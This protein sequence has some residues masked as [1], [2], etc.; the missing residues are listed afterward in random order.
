MKPMARFRGE[1]GPRDMHFRVMPM[2]K[3]IPLYL[4]VAKGKDDYILLTEFA[5]TPNLGDELYAYHRTT[6]V[7]AHP[8][9]YEFVE[10]QPPR[11]VMIGT[12]SWREWCDDQVRPY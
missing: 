12:N 5:Q 2:D 4:R 1:N 11:E 8:T 9:E 10:P 6:E 7:D 3:R